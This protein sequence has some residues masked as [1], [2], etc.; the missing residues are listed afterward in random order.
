MDRVDHL[1]VV[2]PRR[3]AEVILGSACGREVPYAFPSGWGVL[4]E[5]RSV[6]ADLMPAGLVRDLEMKAG[7]KVEFAHQPCRHEVLLTK[8]VINAR[9][10]FAAEVTGRELTLIARDQLFALGELEILLSHNYSC[11]ARTGPPLAASAVT[12]PQGL[13]VSNLILHTTAQA[14]SLD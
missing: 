5:L 12:I 4:G 3:N 7:L 13:R 8:I 1:G 6:V 2:K 14:S 11:E 9:S 10:A